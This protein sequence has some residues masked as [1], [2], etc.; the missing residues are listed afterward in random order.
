MLGLKLNH[1]SKRGHCGQALCGYVSYNLQYFP[2]I[3]HT[4]LFCFLL[5]WL[6]KHALAV[7]VMKSLIQTNIFVIKKY[8][9][10]SVPFILTSTTTNFPSGQTHANKQT[11]ER[12]YLPKYTFW[13]VTSEYDLQNIKYPFICTHHRLHSNGIKNQQQVS[14][15]K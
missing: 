14:R 15:G 4:I 5:F 3:I 8:S 7:N 9:I 12:K 11:V 6:Q 13:Q 10:I 2:Y 1:V